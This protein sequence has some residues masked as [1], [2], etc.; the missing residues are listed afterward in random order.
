MQNNLLLHL[1]FHLHLDLHLQI[2]NV[3]CNSL[4]YE[5]RGR[6]RKF[7]STLFAPS[8]LASV[9]AFAYWRAYRH[10]LLNEKKKRKKKVYCVAVYINCIK[11]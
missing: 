1:H 4:A 8:H 3:D 10:E 5:S 6:T 11:G 9:G 7:E 2:N